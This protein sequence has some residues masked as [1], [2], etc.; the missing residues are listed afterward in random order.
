MEWLQSLLGETLALSQTAAFP[1]DRFHCLLEELPWHLIPSADRNNL[2]QQ[3]D[4]PKDL[5][6]NPACRI[7]DADQVPLELSSSRDLLNGFEQRGTIAWV[8]GQSSLSLRPFW[9]G[10][11]TAEV[12]RRLSSG[13][14]VPDSIPPSMVRI[15][16]AAD[17][18]VSEGRIQKHPDAEASD[19]AASALFRN[20][21][22]VP[23]ENLIH[24]FHVAALRRYYRHR[25]RTGA[26]WLGDDQSRLRYVVHDEPVIRFFHHQITERLSALAGEPLKPSYVYVASYLSGA[27]LKKHT[28]REQCD[29]SITFCLDFSPEPELATPWPIQLDTPSGPVSV[30]Q[31]IGDG[32][33]YRGT[34]LPHYRGVL[35][36]GQT[37]TSVFFHYVSKDFAGPLR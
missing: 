18:L 15:L 24:P 12:L 27:E 2:R 29:F 28:D 10:N 8:K 22:Y 33:A 14:P 21:G 31:A 25:I 6:L 37:S 16:L 32:L 5:I 9:L 7:L 1:P 34:R 4:P 13:D 3:Y 23:V 11:S 17:V 20:E 35:P 19:Q 26:M 36:E 30:Y